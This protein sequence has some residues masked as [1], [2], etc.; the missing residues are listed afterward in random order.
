MLPP[1]LT[2]MESVRA[3]AFWG[4]ALVGWG[5]FLRCQVVGTVAVAALLEQQRVGRHTAAEVGK[6]F[7]RF[8]R[9]SRFGNGHQ[10]RQ[11]QIFQQGGVGHVLGPERALYAGVVG[12]QG[13][14]DVGLYGLV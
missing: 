3:A 1:V 11:G 2:G 7:F 9:P 5:L 12:L 10:A 4:K 14:A 13:G 8:R 6:V